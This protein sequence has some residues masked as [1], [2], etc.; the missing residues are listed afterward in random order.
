MQPTFLK[1]LGMPL[2]DSTCD[3]NLLLEARSDLNTLKNQFHYSYAQYIVIFA[4]GFLCRVFDAISLY[5][6]VVESDYVLLKSK[7][8]A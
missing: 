1:A 3:Y 2:I 5:P 7:L 8:H 6:A 4:A